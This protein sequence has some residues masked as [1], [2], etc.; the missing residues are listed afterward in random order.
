MRRQ[1]ARKGGEKG[2]A[3]EMMRAPSHDGTVCNNSEQD[4]QVLLFHG[5]CRVGG[6]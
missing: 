1:R 4:R 6:L 3:G 5:V 2:G